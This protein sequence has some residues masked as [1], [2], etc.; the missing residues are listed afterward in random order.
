MGTFTSAGVGVTVQTV[1]VDDTAITLAK[2]ADL[3]QDQFIGRTTA[4]TGV[5]Q[6]AT[7]TAAAR[8]VLDD[9]TASAMVDTLGGAAATGTGGIARASSPA[10]VTP[11]LGTP[12]SG[13][14]TNVTGLPAAAVLAGT[15]ASGMRVNPRTTTEVSSATPTINTDNTDIHTITALAVAI[16]SMTTNLSG[17]PVNG[18]RLT[19][20]ILDNATARAI[21]WGASFVSRGATLP[22]TTTLSKYLYVGFLWN[23]TA[24]IWD[25]IATAEE[26]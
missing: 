20:R 18:Q 10:F 7:I 2:M 24:S 25:C 13:V 5:P 6:T 1:E 12:A 16:T 8:T 21:T 15:M 9:T 17:T 23:S 11:A 3:A 26:A 22:T 19:I 4:S 14:M